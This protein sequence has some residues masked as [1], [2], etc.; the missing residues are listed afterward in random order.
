MRMVSHTRALI[1][2]L[3]DNQGGGSSVGSVLE[4]FFLEEPTDLLEFRSRQGSTQLES[5]VPWLLEP[6]YTKPLYVLTNDGTA[7][8]A[9]AFAFALQAQGRCVVVGEPSSGGAYMNDYFPVNPD[10]VISISTSAPFLPGTDTSWD[11]VGV[12]P[13]HEVPSQEALAKALALLGA[14]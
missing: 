14:E 7:S 1:I 12:L 10:F 2:D 4:T 13:D 11:G 5:T 8:A 6:R 3:R 9:E